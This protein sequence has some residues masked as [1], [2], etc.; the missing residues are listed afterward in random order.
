MVLQ[1]ETAV[2]IWGWAAPGEKV[3][4]RFAGETQSAVADGDRHWAI[5]LSPRKAGGPYD[6]DISGINHIAL[7]NV[8][9]GEV[10][11]CGGQSNMDITMERVKEKYPEVIARA[12][13]PYI[14][15]FRVPLHYDFNRPQDDLP[16]GRWE[17]ATPASLLNF[18]AVA[19]FFAKE[20]YERY[21]IPVGLIVNSVGGAPAE[22]WLS[23]GA[24]RSFP[25]AAAEAAKFA[26]SAYIDS[27]ASGERAVSNNWYRNIWQ[28]D[29][30]M[31]DDKPWYDTA[32]DA[33]GWPSMPVPGYWAD[34]GLPRVNGVVWYRKEIDVPAA[35]TGVA[36]KLFLGRIIDRDSV[37]VNGVFS[38]TIGYQYPPRRY[39]LPPG[40][41]R[42]G[43]N[44]IV[45]RVI[46]SAGRGG[47]AP[48]KPYMLTAADQTIDLKG[49]WQYRLGMESP[50]LRE[51]TFF[52]YKPL[53]LYNGMV[54]PLLPYTI[55]GVIWYQGEA[56]TGRPAEYRSVLTSLIA[57]WRGHWG[58]GDFP[59]LYV[60]L[61]NFMPAKEQPSESNWA[62]LR[63]SQREVL[64]VPNTAMAVTIDVGEWNDLHPLDKQDVGHRLGLAAEGVVYGRKNFVYSGPLYQSMKVSGNKARIHFTETSGGLIAKGGGELKGFAIAGADH[65]FV[66]A[67]AVIEGK[68]VVVWNDQVP[69][70]V[71]VRYAWADNPRGANLYNKFFYDT[72]GLPASPFEGRVK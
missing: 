68:T 46:N 15:Q 66:W 5:Q 69:N 70:P 60:Q 35:M 42:P 61:P 7:H 14:R 24:L 50:P 8:Y 52:Q 39:D 59:F 29:K 36:A 33:S 54:A 20:L 4:V 19:Y 27:I 1:R 62:A 58:E 23:V 10:W 21:K 63:E 12:D 31:H 2:R 16:S 56:N 57:D 49:P 6:M 72:D 45:V 64:S 25:A 3:T 65:K 51:S 43:R 71:V 38:G 40:R 32:Y 13:N 34:Q 26:D 22:S 11:V 30:G 44:I 48:D 47:F 41:L 67:K 18:S 53:G 9:V 37:Y 17:A 55:R 28:K